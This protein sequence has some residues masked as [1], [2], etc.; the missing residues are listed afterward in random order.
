MPPANNVTRLLDARKV[1]Y[2]VFETPSEKLG[3]VE[4][5]RFLNV[6]IEIV[7]KTVVITR[8]Q[9]GNRS[10]AG[11]KKFL[12]AVIPGNHVVDLKLLAN[13]IGEK[14]VH[15][16]TEKEAEQIT[17]L[18]AGGISP[19]ALIKKGFQVIVD[20]SARSHRSIHISGGQR[21][22]NILLPVDDLMG[23]TQAR[24]GRI[25]VPGN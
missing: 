22:L 11:R 2:T 25:S 8:V 17:G 13:E 21:S 18:Q 15:L 9:Q 12:L 7:Y 20:E 14:K 23:L 19:L 1:A 4:T 16:P 6:P 5:A 24:F 10:S 3:A